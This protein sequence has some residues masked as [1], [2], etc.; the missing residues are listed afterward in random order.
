MSAPRL[1]PALLGSLLFAATGIVPAICLGE[2]AVGDGAEGKLAIRKV[3]GGAALEIVDGDVPVLRYNYQIVPEPAAVK[4]RIAADNRKYA[5]PRADYIHPLYGPRGEVLTDDWVHDHPHHRGIY[6]AWPEVDWQGNR[7]DLHA[8]QRVF[9][10]PTGKIKVRRG[11]GFAQIE[12]ENEWRWDDRTPIIREQVAIRA[13][14][15]SGAGRC[16]DLSFRFAAIGSDVQVA[17]RATNLYGGLNLRFS[18]AKDQQIATFTDPPGTVQRL[19]WADRSGIPRDGQGVVGLA[20]LQSPHNPDYPGDWVQYA[21]ISW[22]E[23][24]FPAAGTRYTIAK[25][26]PLELQYRL[27]IHEGGLESEA[28]KDLWSAY[29][30]EQ[31]ERAAKGK[32]ST[33]IN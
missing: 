2:P 16:I 18:P 14:R 11:D 26:R 32:G 21:D 31:A 10:R 27:W 1:L 15:K 28:L 3:G 12:A 17:R 9:A 13:G 24:T 19:A 29:N 22:V 6:W 4:D 20:I 30:A 5:A 33:T 25:D 23:P 7:G 8:L